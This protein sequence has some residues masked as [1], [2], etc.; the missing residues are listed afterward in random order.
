MDP[1]NRFD[2]FM[3]LWPKWYSQRRHAF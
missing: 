3:L 2:R 1:L